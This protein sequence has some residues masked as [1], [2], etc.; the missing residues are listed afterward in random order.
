MKNETRQEIEVSNFR[1]CAVI[2]VSDIEKV[3]LE[4]SKYVHKTYIEVYEELLR[5]VK[6]MYRED[7]IEMSSDIHG[8]R[9]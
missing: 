8:T 6:R 1:C 3:A 2:P 5:Y 4:V 7:G 9:P